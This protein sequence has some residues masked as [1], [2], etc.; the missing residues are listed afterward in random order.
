MSMNIFNEEKAKNRQIKIES[1][2]KALH[3]KGLTIMKSIK[4][5][6]SIYNMSLSEAKTLVSNHPVW[7]S[8]AEAAEPLHEDLVKIA[9]NA[10]KDN[11]D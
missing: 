1:T 10:K 9:M 7:R 5:L 2:I 6:M 4:M 8:V 3:D 11:S